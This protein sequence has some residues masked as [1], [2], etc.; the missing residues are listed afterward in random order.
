MPSEGVSASP[1]YV[2]CWIVVLK[3]EPASI[4]SVRGA[5]AKR[6]GAASID[7]ILSAFSQD[8]EGDWQDG[9]RVRIAGVVT[10]ARTKT[11]KNNTLMAYV[12]LEDDTGAMELLVFSRVLGECG[13][14]LKE[15]MALLAEGRI[16]VRD[17]KAPQLMC[18]R[19]APLDRAAGG[20]PPAPPAGGGQAGCLYIRVPSLADPRWEKIKLILTMFP[21]TQQLKVRCADTG[22]LLGAPCLIHE[23]LVAELRELLGA[24]NVAVK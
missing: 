5:M 2:T 4:E 19:I 15:N 17:E 20:P 9:Q 6:C 3:P 21:G 12:T 16:S 10:A 24:E 1:V 23:A 7:P 11:T 22:K 18:D 14:Y 13:P 8:G